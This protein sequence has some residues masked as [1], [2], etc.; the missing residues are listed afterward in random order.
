LSSTAAGE[1]FGI[2]FCSLVFEA[3]IS[4]SITNALFTFFTIQIG[5]FSLS[6]PAWLRGLNHISSLRYM[7]ALTARNEFS[8]QTFDCTPGQL[9]P[10]SDGSLRCP[11]THGEQV[12][13]LYE[14]DTTSDR[15]DLLCVAFL[16]LAYRLIALA[17]LHWSARKKHFVA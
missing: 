15:D 2:L 13:A 5:V 1:S 10:G 12:L 17:T 4:V 9:V 6:M 7:A 11:F 3:G 8:G 16:T 14:F